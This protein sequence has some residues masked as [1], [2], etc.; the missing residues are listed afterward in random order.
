MDDMLVKSFYIG[1]HLAHLTKMFNILHTYNMKLNP[2]KCVFGLSLVK[3][4]GF[5]VNW[6]RIKANPDKINLVLEMET[7]WTVKEI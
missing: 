7:L 1:D 2:N 5:I 4:L 3:C 6:W